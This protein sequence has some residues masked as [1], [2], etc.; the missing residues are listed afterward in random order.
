LALSCE[1]ASLAQRLY[2]ASVPKRLEILR[3][4]GFTEDSS[5]PVIWVERSRRQAFS[6][7]VIVEHDVA[8]LNE[9]LAESVP[10]EFWFYFRDLSADPLKDCRAVL[11]R[12]A[13]AAV[14][15]IVRTGTR[16]EGVLQSN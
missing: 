3:E 9:R 4:A 10:A 1:V 8:W 7:N 6:E 16:R 15:P 11:S 5:L 13:M 14:L 2:R 12:L